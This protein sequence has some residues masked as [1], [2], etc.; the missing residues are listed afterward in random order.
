MVPSLVVEIEFQTW[1]LVQLFDYGLP[2]YGLP[3]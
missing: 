3:S 1:L 2:S